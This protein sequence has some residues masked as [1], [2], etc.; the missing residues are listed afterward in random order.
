MVFV[1][2]NSFNPNLSVTPKL[3]VNEYK[4]FLKIFNYNKNYNFNKDGHIY[5][6]FNKIHGFFSSNF[7]F[8]KIE[9][10]LSTFK[11]NDY[12]SKE[13]IECISDVVLHL[14]KDIRIFPKRKILLRF[15]PTDR[16]YI[17]LQVFE[18]IN[19]KY[20]SIYNDN[21]LEYSKEN[22][23]ELKKNIYCGFIQ[24]TKFEFVFQGIPLYNLNLINFNYFD[25][26]YVKDISDIEK[27]D[28]IKLPDR[29][30]FLIKYVPFLNLNDEKLLEN[31]KE[32]Y[33]IN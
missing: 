18:Y 26:I 14:I 16:I 25:D 2:L 24:N 12:Y 1:T 27:L 15:H 19:T 7:N 23:V 3:N 21:N 17:M 31:L 4:Y 33:N 10:N 32:K 22:L 11:N 29:E 13:M 8:L 28:T 5:I 6:F 20:K 9:K 30:K